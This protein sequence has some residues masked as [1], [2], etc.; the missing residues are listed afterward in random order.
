MDSSKG[1]SDQLITR[2]PHI[3]ISLN[4]EILKSKL[5]SVSVIIPAYRDAEALALALAATDVS[6]A[7]LIVSTAHDDD[8]LAALRAARPDIVWVDAPRGRAQQMNAGAAVAT[9][10]WLV[11]LHADTRLSAGWTDAI[12]SAHRDPRVNAGCFRFALDSRSP[13]A[14]LI[15]GGVRARVALLGLP[16]GDQAIF[17]R[18]DAFHALGGYADLPIMED[19]DLVRRLRRKGRLFRSALPATT[20]A[21]RWERDGWVRRTALHLALIVLYFCGVPPARL[22][23]LDPAR[24]PHP[25]SFG[26]RTSL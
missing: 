4:P 2:R 25:P 3:H 11:F 15:E 24:R 10:D 12:D 5:P 26:R 18:R 8:S 22:I 23:R 6:A 17:V 21:R 20:S 7:N 9:G 1:P 14:R 16:Y 19:V 13:I